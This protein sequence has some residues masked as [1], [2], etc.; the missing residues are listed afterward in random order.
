MRRHDV[1][2][3]QLRRIDHVLPLRPQRRRGALPRIAAVQQ[4][5]AGPRRL[6][7]LDQAGEVREAARGAVRPRRALEIDIRERIRGARA[8]PDAEMPEQRF[9][10]EMRRVSARRPY[11]EIDVRLAEIRRQELR[12]AVG[13]M[14][15]ADVAE[16]RDSIVQRGTV[17]AIERAGIVERQSGSGGDRDRFE[18]LAAVQAWPL[19][20]DR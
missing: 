6:E 5:R 17:M 7:P 10:D 12:V 9:A 3:Q 13:E 4:Q 14:K 11:A 16:R 2:T 8:A 18:K 20:I 19:L 15:E 1:D